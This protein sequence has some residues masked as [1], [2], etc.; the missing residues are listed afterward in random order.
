M[1]RRN[2]WHK[3][4]PHTLIPNEKCIMKFIITDF[5]EKQFKKVVTDMDLKEMMIKIH[6]NSKNFIHFKDPYIKVK[7]RTEN[8][9]Y[10][11]VLVFDQK[12]TNILFI[13]IFDKKDKKY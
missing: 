1:K 8:K 5:F 4:A 6:I 12:E 9:S 2:T 11:I 7:M 13:N 3:R 10:R